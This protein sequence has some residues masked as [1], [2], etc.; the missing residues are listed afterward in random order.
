MRSRLVLA[1]GVGFALTVVL[2]VV[3]VVAT[4][5][6]DSSPPA[7]TSATSEDTETSSVSTETAPGPD[8]TESDG[9]VQ[10]DN[11]KVAL[12]SSSSDG[13]DFDPS[14]INTIQRE[15]ACYEAYLVDVL[16]Q[17]GGEAA[18]L[19][20]QR[21]SDEEPFVLG[22]CHPLTHSIGRAAF[23]KYGSYQA[24]VPEENGTCWSGYT[25]GVLER[26]IFRFGEDELGAALST[27]RQRRVRG[28]A[29]L[30]R[31]RRQLGAEILLQRCLHAEHHRRR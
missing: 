16:H 13:Q 31:A 10:D 28:A 19:E 15:Y 14:C 21:L 4:G 26:L 1:L 18:L 7:A 11:G 23:I 6:D 12:R 30:R 3:L 25:H 29:A 22:E 17:Q 2:V 5:G 9:L 8:P 27:V 20:L 24:A